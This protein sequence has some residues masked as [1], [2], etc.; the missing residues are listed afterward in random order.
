MSRDF[1]TMLISWLGLG[2]VA[3]LTIWLQ[4]PPAPLPATAPPSEFSADRAFQHLKVIARAPRP[5]G[6]AHHGAARDY[7]FRQLRALGLEPEIQRTTAVNSTAAP[8]FF[9]GAIQNIVARRKGTGD[10]RAVLL[11]AHY[12]SVPNGP[13]ANDDAAGVATLLE[14]ARALSAGGEHVERDR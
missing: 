13:G 3:F 2:L 6:S 1:M 11:V 7:I 9:A 8:L 10:G 12:D 4:Q 5:I 14:T